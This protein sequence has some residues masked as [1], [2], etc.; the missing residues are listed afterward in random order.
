MYTFRNQ[1]YG[2]KEVYEDE[3]E[4]NHGVG[5]SD[6]FQSIKKRTLGTSN[7]SPK[8]LATLQDSH[9]ALIA[10][11]TNSRST[12]KHQNPSRPSQFLNPHPHDS[13]FLPPLQ[14]NQVSNCHFCRPPRWP[15]RLGT[16]GTAAGFS[17]VAN[18][19]FCAS[20][21]H[22]FLCVFQAAF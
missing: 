10:A 11:P 7:R 4:N 22:V 20:A 8:Q 18:A 19:C 15:S 9:H 21:A 5:C 14:S 13:A 6:L 17:F 16:L 3:L 12:P 1:T 2:C